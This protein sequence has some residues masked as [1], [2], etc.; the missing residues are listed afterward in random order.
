MTSMR[1]INNPEMSSCL[2]NRG[3]SRFEL[4]FRAGD[5]PRLTAI[6]DRAFQ[7][8]WSTSILMLQEVLGC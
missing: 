4:V 2:F 3:L 7:A 1:S 6:L 8:V 5:G